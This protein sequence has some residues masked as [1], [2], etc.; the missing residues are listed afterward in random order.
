M[1]AMGTDFLKGRIILGY[2]SCLE[3][4]HM[5]RCTIGRIDDP[6]R[7]DPHGALPALL[8]NANRVRHIHPDFRM[9]TWMYSSAY[10]LS[11][12]SKF[13]RRSMRS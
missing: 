11:L 2:I 12:G 10:A 4:P 3:P 13:S 6:R 1:E 9:L 7:L 5:H 8:Q